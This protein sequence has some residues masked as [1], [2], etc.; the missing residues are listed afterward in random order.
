VSTLAYISGFALLLVFLAIV[1]GIAMCS[2]FAAGEDTD[3][4]P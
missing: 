2:H 3:I 4:H 1:I